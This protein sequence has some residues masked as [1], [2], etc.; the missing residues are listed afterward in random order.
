MTRRLLILSPSFHDYDQAFSA[1]FEALGFDTMV[2]L[3]DRSATLAAKLRTKLVH[4]LPERL[5]RDMTAHRA[6][7]ASEGAIRTIRA[8]RPDAVLVIKGD[9]LADDVW[10]EIASVGAA[11]ALWLYDELRRTRWSLDRLR[12]VGSVASYS[13]DD[14]AALRD[15][16]IAATHVPL[17]FDHLRPVPSTAAG[18]GEV[19]FIGARYPRREVVMTAISGAGIPARV[20]G[21]DW[22]K[23]PRDVLRTWGAARPDVPWGRDLARPDAYAVMRGSAAT[24]NIHGNQDGFTIRTFEACGV[25]AVQIVDR[26]EV[27]LYYEPDAEVLVAASADEAVAQ[28]RRVLADPALSSRIREAARARTLAEHTLVHRARALTALLGR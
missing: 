13:S 8:A 7:L 5:G 4:E 19:T 11:H 6:R 17:G 22:S 25:G 27:E 23:D 21:R 15:Q 26:A 16:G 28:C 18:R 2:H 10:A 1:A 24:L 20:F 14:V 9:V 3:Y 12:S